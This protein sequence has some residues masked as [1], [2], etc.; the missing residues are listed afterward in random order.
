[1]LQ[2]FFRFSERE[3]IWTEEVAALERSRA[4]DTVSEVNEE[5]EDI[6]DEYQDDANDGMQ[7]I[8]LQVNE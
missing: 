1:M 3:D 8:Q 7:G 2:F 6:H 5:T 4:T